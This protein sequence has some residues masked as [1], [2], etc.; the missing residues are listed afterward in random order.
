MPWLKFVCFFS[1]V[2]SLKDTINISL[3]F[4]TCLVP[5]VLKGRTSIVLLL[6]L[7]LVIT[8]YLIIHTERIYEDDEMLVENLLLWTRDSKNKLLFLERPDKYDLFLR[9]EQYI[10][11]GSSSQKNSDLDDEGRSTL[12]EVKY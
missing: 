7:L 2:N 6:Q 3:C 11:I 1:T 10:L 5:K 9:P 4:S 8:I 12:I